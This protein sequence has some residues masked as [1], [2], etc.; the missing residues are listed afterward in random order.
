MV[1]VTASSDKEE[2]DKV[3]AVFFLKLFGHYRSVISAISDNVSAYGSLVASIANYCTDR[4]VVLFEHKNGELFVGLAER[5]FY[6]GSVSSVS[7]VLTVVKLKVS[8]EC[9]TGGDARAEASINFAKAS[10]CKN[11]SYRL[12]PR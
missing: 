5:S 8:A 1:N 12:Q 4:L 6:I 9:K 2:T 3:L 11:Y 10:V 7:Y